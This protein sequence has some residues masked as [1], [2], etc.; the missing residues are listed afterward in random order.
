MDILLKPTRL[1]ISPICILPSDDDFLRII[2][3]MIDDEEFRN[4]EEHDEEDAE[5]LD[6]ESDDEEDEE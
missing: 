1:P 5:E 4:S 3:P 6:D 2:V